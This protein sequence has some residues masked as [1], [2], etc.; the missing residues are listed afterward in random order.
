MNLGMFT[1]NAQSETIE[2]TGYPG[3]HFSLEGA[4]ELF[5]TSDN[6]EDFEKKLNQEDSNV[7]NLDLDEDGSIDYIRVEDNMDGD[8]HAIVLQVFVS[9][10]EA[11]DIAVI[12]IEKTGSAS[13]VL[14]IV[15]NEDIFGEETYV[16]PFDE[17][18][19][20]SGSGPDA[21]YKLVRIVVNV[22]GWSTVRFVYA[23]GYR[24]YVSPWRWRYYPTWYR[25]WR[26]RPFRTFVAAVTPFRAKYR[27]VN[28]HRVVRAHK[29]YT[30]RKKTSVTV[31]RNVTVTRNNKSISKSTSVAGVRGSN[32]GKAAGKKT[33]VTA[34][35]GNKTVT[36]TKA[37][38]IKK[39]DNKTV[40]KTQKTKVKKKNN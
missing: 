15:G 32:G 1:L 8:V 16:E 21:E 23:P 6:L 20:S 29:I 5:K 11:Q 30:P 24:V 7:N 19:S 40:K 37:T 35:N 31:K 4:L 9:E 14:Q 26:P 27:V 3:D 17:V 10:D 34:T 2:E 18:A 28:T 36:K 39:K 25:P 12:E 38:G 22:W 13:A 33:T